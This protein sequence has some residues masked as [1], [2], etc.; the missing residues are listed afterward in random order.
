MRRSGRGSLLRPLPSNRFVFGHYPLPVATIHVASR[1]CESIVS[2]NHEDLDG[3]RLHSLRL[4]GCPARTR[5]L[6]RRPTSG[7]IVIGSNLRRSFTYGMAAVNSE[8]LAIVFG[9]SDERHSRLA[10]RA[11]DSQGAPHPQ[12]PCI[13]RVVIR[14]DRCSRSEASG[15]NVSVLGEAAYCD[16]ATHGDGR[17]LRITLRIEESLA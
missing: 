11:R 9:S 8:D 6:Q 17:W 4:R 13:S 3:N 5:G 16:S 14:C 1:L 7:G 2:A 15:A 12:P 10:D